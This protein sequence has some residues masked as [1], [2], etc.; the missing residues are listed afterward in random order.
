MKTTILF[1]FFFHLIPG[2]LL[3]A[4]V[5][6]PVLPESG[7]ASR[8][9]DSF[10]D[11]KID[12][13]KFYG[14]VSDRDRSGNV[15]KIKVENNNTKFFRVGDKIN[16][17]TPNDPDDICEA[18]IRDVED[19][20][21]AA[22]IRDLEDC[23]G[24]NEVFRIGSTL[25]M[26]SE[27]LKE[28]VLYASQYRYIL[29]KQHKDLLSQLSS[30]NNDIAFY[31]QNRVQLVAE[32]DK[33]MAEL[34]RQK[35]E[36]LDRLLWQKGENVKLQHALMRRLDMLD[37]NIKFYRIEREEY[38]TDRWHLDHDTGL[39]MGKRPQDEVKVEKK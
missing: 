22:Y 8:D 18:F 25:N 33:R 31:Q 11:Y 7:V 37:E 10:L 26:S 15:V 35:S 27:V 20:Y 9:M 23:K 5:V 34:Q 36:A 1:L 17:A 3:W 6:S 32:Y 21:I 30:V 19:Y 16:L 4:D 24:K 28:R 39:P 38:I 14:R 12:Y 29:L 13:E 2:A